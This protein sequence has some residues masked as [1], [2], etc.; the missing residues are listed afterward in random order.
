MNSRWAS[1]VHPL[2]TAWGQGKCKVRLWGVQGAVQPERVGFFLHFI[3]A[4]VCK[5]LILH[6]K[7]VWGSA[8]MPRI[9]QNNGLAETMFWAVRAVQALMERGR[10]VGLP[11]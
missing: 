1:L 10:A 3:P 4:Y 8:A 5:S 2:Y 9:S 7:D 11:N 6:V